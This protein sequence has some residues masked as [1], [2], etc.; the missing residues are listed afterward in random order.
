MKVLVVLLWPRFELNLE[1]M[2]REID[3]GNQVTVLECRQELLG[4]W[5]NPEH[6]LSFCDKCC[7][8]RHQGLALVP[9]AGRRIPLLHLTDADRASLQRLLR[10]PTL[11]N[12]LTSFHLDG[13][14]LGEAVM[15]CMISVFRDP[16]VNPAQHETMARNLA[17]GTMS[18]FYSLRN[19]LAAEPVDRV[20][21]QGGR[22]SEVR[23]VLRACQQRGV[24]CLVTEVGSTINR[25]EIYENSYFHNL[26]YIEKDMWRYWNQAADP[27]ER[28]RVADHFYQS[29]TQGVEWDF[30]SFVASQ[31][32]GLLPPDFDPEQHNVAI[33]NSSEDEFA[34][35]G[36]DFRNPIYR[37][38]LD[39]LRRIRAD[40]DHLP[41]DVKLYLRIHPNLSRVPK[42]T[43]P[44]LE[45]DAPRFRVI[46]P[47][48][49]VS[50][51]GLMRGCRKVLTFGSTTGIEAV[52]WGKPSILAGVGFYQSLGGN[53]VAKNH[54]EVMQLLGADL[55]PKDKQAAIVYGYWWATFG[56][57]FKHYQAERMWAGQ[58]DATGKFKGRY[59]RVP[60]WR[61]YAWAL[62]HRLPPLER[63][64]NRWHRWQTLRRKLRLPAK[65][66]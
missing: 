42:L 6:R 57:P 29:R 26:A 61:H 4:C 64:L 39:G 66:S 9:G 47:D 12:D 32:Q 44:L 40:L 60:R 49:P 51:Y 63:L 35:I 36:K 30:Y 31:K 7:R 58:F 34:A 5:G 28:E 62:V 38:Q 19:V 2:Q 59:L 41:G 20:Y 3:A 48:S 55:K 33:F 1:A 18:A 54:D 8:L 23:A 17:V 22:F 46:P 10:D 43:A 45:L 21:V 27:A 24:E 25:Y 16:A 11:L 56:I 53:Y 15:S 14:D 52:Y 65:G 50:T 37:D 13:F